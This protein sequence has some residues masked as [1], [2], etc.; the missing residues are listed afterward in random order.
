M[1]EKFGHFKFEPIN[2]DLVK[3]PKVL[4]DANE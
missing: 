3:V 2:Q 1:V 4:A